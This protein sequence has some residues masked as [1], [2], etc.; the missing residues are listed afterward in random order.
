MVKAW[1]WKEWKIVNYCVAHWIKG[2]SYKI[3]TYWRII[4]GVVWR[5]GLG[6]WW[7]RNRFRLFWGSNTWYSNIDSDFW[8]ISNSFTSCGTYRNSFQR[9]L[10][11]NQVTGQPRALRFLFCNLPGERGS[12]APEICA[13]GEAISVS[14]NALKLLSTLGTDGVAQVELLWLPTLDTE[15]DEDDVW[16]DV[17]FSRCTI[18]KLVLLLES[19][20]P[21]IHN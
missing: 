19:E 16:R 7:L 13:C 17:T 2:L 8:C 12:S 6:D 15:D 21:E 10:Q 11:Y 4:W 20:S 5:T 14:S 3:M 1:L 9:W 18:S